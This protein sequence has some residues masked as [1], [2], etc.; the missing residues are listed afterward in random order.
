MRR[1]LLFGLLIFTFNVNQSIGQPSLPEKGFRWV[2]NDQLSDEF[3]GDTLNAEIWQNTDTRWIGRPPGLFMF[4]AVSVDDGKMRITTDMLP[5]PELINGNTFTHQGGHVRS[6]NKVKPGS[7][8]ECRMKANKTFMS[9]TF[10]LINYSNESSGCQRRTTEL[11][12][13][14]C[15]GFPDSKTQTQRM[16]SN[17]HS[18]GIPET[19]SHIPSG[20]QGDHIA[21]PGKVYDHYYTYGVWWKGPKELHFYLNGEYVY[22]ITPKADF[23]L[24]MYIK[25]VVETYNWNPVPEDGGMTGSW[26]ER[27]TYYD[28][29]RTYNYLPIDEKSQSSNTIF[30]NEIQFTEKPVSLPAEE[31]NFTVNYKSSSDTKIILELRDKDGTLVS[32]AQHNALAGYGNTQINMDNLLVGGD[33]TIVASL[34]DESGQILLSSTDYIVEIIGRVT[35]VQDESMEIFKI[36][37]NPGDHQITLAGLDEQAEFEIHTATG[38]LV[39]TGSLSN[40][41]TEIDV[42]SLPDAT[43]ILKLKTLGGIQSLRFVKG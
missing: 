40:S 8:T 25:L 38:G 11:D 32:T 16:G 28:W 39:L 19:C 14:E 4:D 9:S 17:T 23:D 30:E 24:D 21:T 31:I 10:W 2:L 42:S 5:A 18:R 7:F 12:V 26:D 1:F 29:I 3:D 20:S 13:Q 33:Y 15:I 22:S 41:N 36:I 6:V 27:T 43:Y 35:A 37:P 34:Y